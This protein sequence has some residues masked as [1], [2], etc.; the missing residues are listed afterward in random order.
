MVKKKKSR[1]LRL[2]C[3][4]KNLKNHNFLDGLNS[5]LDTAKQTNYSSKK[6]QWIW[7]VIWRDYLKEAR[8]QLLSRVW[9]FLTPWT[10]TCQA[11]LW[12]SRQEYWSRLPFPI[13]GDLP[14]PAIKPTSPVSLALAG[15]FF[16]TFGKPKSTEG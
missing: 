4:E 16:T 12:F 9:F 2:F 3:F 11:A 10:I 7:K 14:N 8:S 1:N 13:P 5:T 6:K 15:R